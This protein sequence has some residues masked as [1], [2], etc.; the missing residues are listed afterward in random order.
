MQSVFK[1]VPPWIQ[2]STFLL[3]G[4][5]AYYCINVATQLRKPAKK[6]AVSAQ[7][8]NRMG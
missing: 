7:T 4:N 6:I 5:S 1:N 3:W 8:R 2:D